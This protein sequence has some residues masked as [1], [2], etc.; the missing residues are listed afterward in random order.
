MRLISGR[1]QKVINKKPHQTARLGKHPLSP[2]RDRHVR[3]RAELALALDSPDPRASVAEAS[4]RFVARGGHGSHHLPSCGALRGPF[5]FRAES[6]GRNRAFFQRTMMVCRS[7]LGNRRW[8]PCDRSRSANPTP[9]RPVLASAVDR[10]R[11]LPRFRLRFRETLS[12][13]QTLEPRRTRIG[14]AFA[15]TPRKASTARSRVSEA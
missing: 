8:A 11:R 15:S 6:G 12:A 13:A 3:A 1:L 14:A 9:L 2:L 10:D 4:T 5:I 7:S